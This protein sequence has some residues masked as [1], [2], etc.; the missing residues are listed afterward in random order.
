MELL[1]PEEVMEKFRLKKRKT[2]DNWLYYGTLPRKL[3]IKVGGNL[4]FLKDKLDEFLE[5]TYNTQNNIKCA[6]A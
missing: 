4:Y 3:T 6:R 2:L 5:S 1:T